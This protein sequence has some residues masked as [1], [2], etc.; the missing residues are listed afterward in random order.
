MNA[1][2]RAV[3]AAG[4]AACAVGSLG[5]LPSPPEQPHN[6]F[7]PGHLYGLGEQQVYLVERSETVTVRFRNAD[8]D[9]VTRTIKR[10]D[11]RSL[12]FT[13]EG[14]AMDGSA[15]VAVADN[16]APATIEAPPSPTIAADGRFSG[17]PLSALSGTTL[18]V[19]ATSDET[20][21]D[22]GKWISSGPLPLSIGLQSLRLSNDASTWGDDASVLQVASTGTFDTGGSV[23]VQGFGEASLRGNGSATGSSYI[24]LRDRLLLGTSLILRSSGNA[25]GRRGIGTF[26]LSATYAIK[27]MRYV[28]GLL[29]APK[30]SGAL[31]PRNDNIRTGAPPDNLTREGAPDQLTRPA[32]TDN[33]FR[34]SPAPQETPTPIPDA[35]LPPVPI[36]VSSGLPLASPPAPPPTPIPTHTPH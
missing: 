19:G 16:A 3:V 24:D 9:L 28:P 1:T 4:L 5:F 31:A 34:G 23:K 13:V 21:A 27:L 32:P 17:D 12:A 7:L 6:I 33:I 35:S 36:P 11:R 8:D 20:I 2:T 25:V 10:L 22:G 14:F 30:P 29:P 18:I 26:T 15:V